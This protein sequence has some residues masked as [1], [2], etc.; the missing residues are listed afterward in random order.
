MN[1]CIIRHAKSSWAEPSQRDFDR[2]LNKRGNADGP[3][4]AAWLANQSHPAQW[5]WT[6]SA[7]RAQ[8]TANFVADGFRAASPQIVRDNRLYHAGVHELVDVLRE[9]PVEAQSVALVAHNPG[10]TYLVNHLADHQELDNLPTFG[11]AQFEVQVPWHELAPHNA[12][13]LQVVSPNRL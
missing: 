4:M 3:R 5:I 11:I 12:A 2:P 6:S 8:A 1:L 9:T 10:L 7:A 13:L